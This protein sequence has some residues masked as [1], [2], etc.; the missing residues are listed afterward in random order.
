MGTKV[1]FEFWGFRY[2]PAEH[3]LLRDG[4]P[5]SLTPKAFD[6]LQILLQS[7]GR[8]LSK[9]ELMNRIWPNSFVEE[10]NLTVNISA[11]RKALGDRPDGGEYIETVP[12]R[13]YRFIAEVTELVEDGESAR[14]KVRIVVRPGTPAR[15]AEP[16]VSIV[17]ASAA[18]LSA[19]PR[20]SRKVVIARLVAALAITVIGVLLYRQH[21]ARS[22]IAASRRLA[23]LPFQNLRQDPD[24]DFLGYSLADAVITKLGYLNELNVSLQRQSRSIATK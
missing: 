18:P 3:L 14:Q 5:V 2:D 17:S 24:S 16:P 12:K 19:L 22:A 13:G 10:A 4:K 6:I 23:I 11:L 21:V 8:L 9:E 7:N 15:E 1:L 20:R